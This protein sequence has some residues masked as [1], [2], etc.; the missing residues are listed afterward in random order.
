MRD[1]HFV[2]QNCPKLAYINPLPDTMVLCRPFEVAF[3][4]DATN[5]VSVEWDFGDP[6]TTNDHSTLFN[7]TYTYPEPGTYE[8]TLYALNAEGCRDTALAEAVVK[9]AVRPDFDYVTACPGEPVQFTSTSESNAG[10]ITGYQWVFPN[11]DTMTGANPAY[12]FADEGTHTVELTIFTA[13]NCVETITQHVALYPVPDAN[14][15]HQLVCLDQPVQFNEQ[16]NIGGGDSITLYQWDFGDGGAGSSVENPQHTFTDTGTYEVQLV[17]TSNNGC[18]D[19]IIKEVTVEPRLVAAVSADTSTCNDKPIQLHASGGNDYQWFPTNSISDPTISSPFASPSKPTAYTVVVSDE[20][21]SDTAH[22][23][24]AIHPNPTPEFDYTP[25]CSNAPIQF[26]DQSTQNIEAWLWDYGDGNTDSLENPAYVFNDNG[27]HAVSLTVTNNYG[28]DSAITQEVVP[29]E[30]PDV[31]YSTLQP[32]CL[33]K[34]AIF[35]DTTQMARDSITTW[36]WDLGDGTTATT[37]TVTH[38]YQNTGHYPVTLILETDKGC[39]DSL[40]KTYIVP[41]IVIASAS[42]DTTIC[43]HD[44]AP[45]EA[46]GASSTNGRL[47]SMPIVTASSAT[48]LRQPLLHFRWKTRSIP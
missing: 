47:L 33:L 5:A 15:D 43:P 12:T 41:N 25:A 39:I 3:E 30:V 24:V 14:F 4:A 37:D 23:Q 21:A 10:A 27:P 34:P 18:V 40:T 20:C 1:Y 19:T 8:V 13:D 16:S 36:N 29:W 31:L 48:T 46:S 11:G 45:V 2:V 28:C 38:T 22:V 32:T 35:V 17:V 26:T 44:K 6:S 7:P 42:G 9:N